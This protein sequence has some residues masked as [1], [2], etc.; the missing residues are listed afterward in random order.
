MAATKAQRI[1]IWVIAG[2]MLVG[3]VGSFV[4]IVLANSN[5]QTDKQRAQAAYA[6]YQ[7]EYQAKVNVQAS[8]LSKIYYG[9]F[10]QYGSRPAAFDAASVT[11]LKTIDLL[12]GTG[13]NITADSSFTAYYIGWNPTGKVFDGSIEGG[14]LKAPFNVEPGG[15]IKGWTKGVVGMKVGGVRELTI[16]SSLAYGEAGSGKDIPANTPIKFVVMII[17]A[18]EK[19][20]QPVPSDQ[21]IKYSQ[22]GLL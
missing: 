5:Q 16:P 19:I 2:F 6:A 1:G 17:P 8:E 11:E 14:A 9:T 15:V 3:T 4:A 12:V 21:L 10:S 20:V 22:Q 18:P 13:E 7:K